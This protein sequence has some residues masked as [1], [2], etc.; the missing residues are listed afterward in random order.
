MLPIFGRKHRKCDGLSRRD[1]LAAGAMGFG[2][3]SLADLLRSEAQAGI[4]GSHKAII[5]IHLDGGPPQMDMID[6]KPDAPKEVRGEF[7]PISTKVPGLYLSEL[8]PKTASIADKIAFI[9]SLVGS[10]GQ[11]NAYQCMS[12]FDNKDMAAMGGRPAMGSVIAKLRGSTRDAA[13]AFVDMMQGRPLA[14][15]SARPG[16]LGPS[17]GP[18]R[19]DISHLFSR[20][21]EDGMV[22]ELAKKGANH[23]TSLSLGDGLTAERLADRTSLLASM[24]RIR[25]DVDAS[26]MM[27]A[28]DRFTQQAVGILT[29][30]KFADA[31]DLSKEDPKVVE[32][33]T[34]KQIATPGRFVTSDNPAASRK[35]LIARRLIEAGVRCVSLTLSDFDTHSGNFLRLRQILPIFDH[36]LHALITDLHERG[37]LDDVSIV[38][39]GEFGRT[40]KINAKAGRDHWPRVGMAMLAGGGMRGGQVIGSTDRTASAVNTRPVHYQEV[41]ATLYR[42]LGF[43]LDRTTLVDPTGRPRYLLERREV[44]RELV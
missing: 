28:A 30:G 44:I 7:S 23:R 6:P 22:K 20:K 35:L 38:C 8:L 32:R 27:D 39:W 13:P 4:G 26:G 24:D 40:P 18:F 5:N 43:D 12:G 41:L 36:A 25:R 2:S 42:N 1:F 33:Y 16:F 9:R 15:N 10:T 34:L 29:S 14:R 21:L 3:F 11:H 37:M 17:F 19:P 31:L